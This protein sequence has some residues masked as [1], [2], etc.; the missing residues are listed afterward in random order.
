MRL[1][2]GKSTDAATSAND[3]DVAA[4]GARC[5]QHNTDC[6]SDSLNSRWEQRTSFLSET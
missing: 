3:A 2:L 5:A 6:A 1:H 4:D